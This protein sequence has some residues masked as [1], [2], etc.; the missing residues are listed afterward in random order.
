MTL[1]KTSAAGP[2][3]LATDTSRSDAMASVTDALSLA[4]TKKLPIEGRFGHNTTTEPLKENLFGST[5]ALEFGLK[6]NDICR[7]VWLRL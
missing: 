2:M 3:C 4:R 7:P 5:E 6:S 1:A